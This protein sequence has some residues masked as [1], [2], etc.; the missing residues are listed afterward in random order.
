VTVA[1]VADAWMTRMTGDRL[2]RAAVAAVVIL[3]VLLPVYRLRNQRWVEIA[4]LSADTMATLQRCS[5]VRCHAIVLE[6][7]PTTRRNFVSAFGTFDTGARLFLGREVATQIL[8][9][10]IGAAPIEDGC[11]LYLRLIANVPRPELRGPCNSL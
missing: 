2:R 9:G 11:V 7:D 3:T 1:A 4:D 5:A 6:D 8:S 10:Q